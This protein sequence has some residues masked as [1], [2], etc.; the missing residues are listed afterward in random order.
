MLY[1]AMQ[2]FKI[3]TGRGTANPPPPSAPSALRY[4][5]PSKIKSFLRH[6]QY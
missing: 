1:V 2:N 5:A 6:W 3:S 4:A